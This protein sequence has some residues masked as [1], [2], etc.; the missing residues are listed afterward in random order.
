VQSGLQGGGGQAVAR[1][2]DLELGAAPLL[3]VGLAGQ[4]PGEAAGLVAAGLLQHLV[5]VL[6]FGFL[7]RGQGAS[8]TGHLL[9]KGEGFPSHASAATYVGHSLPTFETPTLFSLC[10][11]FILDIP[12][13]PVYFWSKAGAVQGINDLRGRFAFLNP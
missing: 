5:E 12:L 11:H 8:A 3:A 10:Y 7:F 1:V 6:G 2:A 13:M 4:E 9:G